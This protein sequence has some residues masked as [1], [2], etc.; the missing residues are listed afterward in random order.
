MSEKKRRR[1][2]DFISNGFN[3]IRS[4]QSVVSND[5][6]LNEIRFSTLRMPSIRSKRAIKT[7][8]TQVKNR[9]H[10]LDLC[11]FQTRFKQNAIECATNYAGD[12][13]VHDPIA[14]L[15]FSCATETTMFLLIVLFQPH[16]LQKSHS[17]TRAQHLQCKSFV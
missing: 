5:V 12:L 8:G 7:N 10:H 15:F 4:I 9:Y 16:T 6:R 1:V 13:S 14:I 2:H 17:L 11:I 3:T